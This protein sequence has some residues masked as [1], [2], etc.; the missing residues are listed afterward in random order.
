MPVYGFRCYDDEGGCD[1]YFEINC[2]MSEIEGKKPSCPNCEAS[3]SVFRDFDGDVYVF[4]SSPKTV[5]ALADRNGARMSQDQ[6][7]HIKTKNRIQKPKFTG[8]LPEGASLLPVDKDGRKIMPT[9]M[10]KDFRRKE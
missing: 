10:G 8:S 6:I 5:G 3:S 2:P 9:R 7:N 4:D 1:F